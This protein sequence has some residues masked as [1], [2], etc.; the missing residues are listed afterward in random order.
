[1][2]ILHLCNQTNVGLCMVHVSMQFNVYLCDYMGTF[3]C[4]RKY[5]CGRIAYIY[6]ATYGSVDC[7]GFL[8]LSRSCEDPNRS[9]I[10]CISS[11]LEVKRP[12]LWDIFS[13]C[14]SFK[15]QIL[16]SIHRHRK[17]LVDIYNKWTYEMT[18]CCKFTF[19]L[20]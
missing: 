9:F 16:Q 7:E 11:I 15:S 6:H 12:Y 17:S 13:E 18:Y 3:T 10:I 20:N 8:L 14:I 1:M 5:T 19:Y 2:R 4:N